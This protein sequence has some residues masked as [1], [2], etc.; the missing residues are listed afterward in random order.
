[1]NQDTPSSC[2]PEDLPPVR[3]QTDL[4]RLWRVLM[5]R[6]G[7]DSARIFFQFIPPDGRSVGFLGEIDELPDL[8]NQKVADALL[9]SCRYVIDRDLPLGTRVAML[10]ARPGRTAPTS[11]DRRWGQALLRAAERAAVPMWQVHLATDR[12]LRVLTP[13][14]LVEPA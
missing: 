11:H 3:C 2:R 1:M 13:D 4:H 14:D 7:F 12:E 8:P 9:Q 10:Y 5:G 6:L